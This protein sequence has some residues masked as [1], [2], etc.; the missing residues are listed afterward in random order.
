MAEFAYNKSVHSALGVSPYFTE[1]GRNPRVD[2]MAR[3]LEESMLVPNSPAAPDRVQ[4]L[5]KHRDVLS[6]K[7]REATEAQRRYAGSRSKAHQFSVGDRVW[8]STKNLATARPSKKLDKKFVGSF[9]VLVRMS[10]GDTLE[11]TV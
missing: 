8:L 6:G 5:L 2:D 11:E 4:A 10:R 7:L 3:L 9:T 1:T